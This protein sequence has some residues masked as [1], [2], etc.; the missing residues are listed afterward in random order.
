MLRGSVCRF[1]YYARLEKEMLD[2]RLFM[3]AV[4]LNHLK[5]FC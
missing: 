3:D 5:A 4:V 1:G 2:D